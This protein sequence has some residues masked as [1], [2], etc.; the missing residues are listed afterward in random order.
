MFTA[1]GV[2]SCGAGI[3]SSSVNRRFQRAWPPRTRAPP[4][5]RV[6]ARVAAGHRLDVFHRQQSRPP[7]ATRGVI[8]FLD[9]DLHW[10]RFSWPFQRPQYTALPPHSL[11]GAAVFTRAP[12]VT[13]F[14]STRGPFTPLSNAKRGLSCL[15][16]SA[17]T[18]FKIVH[19]KL[20]ADI[21]LKLRSKNLDE[22]W[23]HSGSSQEPADEDDLP[24]TRTS[25]GEGQH[26][27]S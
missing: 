9:H 8:F 24:L 14:L 1:G 26:P 16:Y 23:E 22:Q 13:F 10:A 4:V 25:Q 7:Q 6:A 2:A 19:V 18:R 21:S 27:S 11:T 12:S 3:S 17:A 15:Y 5:P 20:V